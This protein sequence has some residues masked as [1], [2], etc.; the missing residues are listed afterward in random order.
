MVS[1]G[2]EAGLGGASE[3]D[4]VC[5]IGTHRLLFGLAMCTGARGRRGYILGRS[6]TIASL[7]RTA[8]SVRN[9]KFERERH[10]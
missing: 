3:E 10:S 6:R 1:C 5:P 9:D 4:E 8:E 2:K 7:D